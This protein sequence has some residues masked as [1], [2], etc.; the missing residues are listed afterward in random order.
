MILPTID[1]YKTLVVDG[2]L[3]SAVA[4]FN[5]NND[6]ATTRNVAIEKANRPSAS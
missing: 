6:M 1:I 2:D 4:E 3:S 5:E